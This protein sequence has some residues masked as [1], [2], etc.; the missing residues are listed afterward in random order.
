MKRSLTFLTAFL[1][2]IAGIASAAAPPKK[3]ICRVC[4]VHEG[5]DEPE[6]VVASATYEGREY[7]FCSEKCKKTFEEDPVA[8]VPPVLPRPA[9]AFTLKALDGK[10]V[11]SQSFQGK[12]VLVDFW[13]TWCQPCVT[14]MPRLE[15]LHSELA[16]KGFAVVGVSIDEGAEGQKKA[17]EFVQKRK[18]DYPMYLDATATPA[19][20]VFHVRA[21]PAMF[22]IDAQGRVVRQWTGKVDLAEVEKAARDLVGSAS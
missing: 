7:H 20:S 4:Q 13:A 19:W 22:L 3:A 5:E 15:K 18:I 1:I 10:E 14:A 11:A 9:P 12:A 2:L 21:I 8:Y 6:K 16:G 17:Q